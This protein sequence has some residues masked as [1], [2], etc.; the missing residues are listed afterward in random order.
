MSRSP[1]HGLLRGVVGAVIVGAAVL[2]GVGAPNQ[3]PAA[4]ALTSDD[5]VCSADVV[6]TSERL[7]DAT[8]RVNPPHERMHVT[9]AHELATGR[10]SKVAVIDSGIAG[11]PPL[12]RYPGTAAALLSGHGTIVAGL[13]TGTDGVAPDAEVYDVRVFDEEAADETQGYKSLTSAGIAAGIRAVIAALPR[14]PVDVV[15]ISLAVRQDD[16]VL[17]A[18]VADL[19]A[20][21]VVVVA[22][23]GNVAAPN[24]EN[25]DGTPGSDARIYPADYPGV[26]A[27]SAIA[28]SG[29]DPG[30]Y[31]VPNRDTDVAAPTVGAISVNATGSRCVIPD[32]ATSWAAA[33]VSGVLALLHE[34]FPK[35]NP[36]QLVARL[37]GTAEG[38]GATERDGSARDPW[39]GAGVVQ[40]HEAL[41]RQLDITPDGVVRGSVREAR[42]GAQAPPAPAKTDRYGSARALL[43]WW[44]LLAGALLA[45]ALLLR[46]LLRRTPRL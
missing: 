30:S 5:S 4:G 16:P 13:I 34:R 23:A 39:S 17:R 15:N 10:G 29:T 35:A 42:S 26:V 27:V 24:G 14:Q 36:R 21:D 3:L 33:Q 12:Y 37:R 31:V 8:T 11:A 20:R 40:A 46:P 6:A 25:F 22:A 28:P 44:G 38:S 1:S 45:L 7:A 32:V 9:Q 43:Q 18:A 19:V 41:T 2:V